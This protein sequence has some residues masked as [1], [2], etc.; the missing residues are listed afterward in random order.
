MTD[1][2]PNIT[3]S[4]K[5]FERAEKIIPAGTQ[6][7]SKGVTQFVN[8]F[9]PKYLD[10]GVGAYVWDVDGNKFLDYIMQQ[11]CYNCFCIKF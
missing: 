7:F 3:R 6:T 8:G 4:N 2:K 11:A 10:R 5:I 1:Q 9:A